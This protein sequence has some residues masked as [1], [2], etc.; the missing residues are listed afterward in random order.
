M[1]IQ[2]PQARG[3]LRAAV[4]Q[5]LADDR[6]CEDA[7]EAGSQHLLKFAVNRRLIAAATRP[8]EARELGSQALACLAG[9]GDDLWQKLR[10]RGSGDRIAQC[11]ISSDARRSRGSAASL[12]PRKTSLPVHVRGWSGRLDRECTPRTDQLWHL[13]GAQVCDTGG[14][15]CREYRHSQSSASVVLTAPRSTRSPCPFRQS[16]ASQ[17]S[18]RHMQ[19][20]LRVPANCGPSRLARM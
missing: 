5:F 3:S 7:Y 14:R 15:R 2:E 10:Q 16:G 20:F 19:R 18:R 12:A 8:G 4:R 6:R 17:P 11:L 9:Q 1:R 13:A